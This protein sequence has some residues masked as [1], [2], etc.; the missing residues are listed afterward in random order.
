MEF[1]VDVLFL[2]VLKYFKIYLFIG[3]YLCKFFC[4]DVN[5]YVFLIFDIN[6]LLDIV[7]K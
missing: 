7:R 5:R 1:C 4:I 2:V 3:F 6:V